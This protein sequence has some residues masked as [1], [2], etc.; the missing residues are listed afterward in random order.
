VFLVDFD[1]EEKLFWMRKKKSKKNVS[2]AAIFIGVVGVPSHS[3]HHHHHHHVK[4]HH[5]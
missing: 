2:E 3:T 5:E 1:F 4:Q